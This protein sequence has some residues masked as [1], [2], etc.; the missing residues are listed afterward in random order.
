MSSRP[1]KKDLTTFFPALTTFLLRL[2]A[3]RITFVKRYKVK[4]WNCTR[5]GVKPQFKTCRRCK[6]EM[7]Q[8]PRTS[9]DRFVNLISLGTSRQSRYQCCHCGNQQLFK[10]DQ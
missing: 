4:K 1:W 8:V 9:F 3:R 2:L 6:M 7:I 10:A 5:T